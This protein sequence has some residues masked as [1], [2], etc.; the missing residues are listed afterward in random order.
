MKPLVKEDRLYK[1]VLQSILNY[2]EEHSIKAGQRLPSE[3]LLAEALNVSRTT[4]KEAISVLEANGVL[5][6]KQGVWTF[7]SATCN[8]QMNDDVTIML[9]NQSIQFLNLIELRQAIEGD[10]AF[11]AA[12]RITETQKETLIS[13]HQKLVAAE[14]A[15]EQAINEDLEFHMAISEA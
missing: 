12:K 9:R 3:R 2:I 1:K 10:I 13:A 15:G 8:Q 11:Y 14:Q 4:V 5:H 6:I 7:L